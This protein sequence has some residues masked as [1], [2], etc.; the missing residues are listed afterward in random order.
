LRASI[1]L[2]TENKKLKMIL[3]LVHKLILNKALIKNKKIKK[4]LKL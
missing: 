2:H 1:H 4:K 3:I